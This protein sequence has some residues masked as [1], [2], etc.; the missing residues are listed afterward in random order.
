M[1]T[2]H[3]ISVL[4]LRT[5]GEHAFSC[6]L[7]H[8]VGVSILIVEHVRHLLLFIFPLD[9]E[10]SDSWFL[11]KNVSSKLGDVWLH[12]WVLIELW[13]F[14]V[15]IHVITNTEEFLL[16]VGASQQDSSHSDYF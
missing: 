10:L 2:H 11:H 14:I 15:V 9:L 1:R 3:V 8:S 16:I 4:E 5:V 13:F 6:L 12:G 7:L